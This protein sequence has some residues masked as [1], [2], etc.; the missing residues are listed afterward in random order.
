MIDCQLDRQCPEAGDNRH[1]FRA[2]FVGGPW[3]GRT[4][5]VSLGWLERPVSFPLA[6]RHALK[7]VAGVLDGPA[8]I[9]AVED[10]A[11]VTLRWTP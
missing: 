5:A 2:E 3:D 1:S 7:P 10:D 11:T 6:G 4:R 9:V 8:Y